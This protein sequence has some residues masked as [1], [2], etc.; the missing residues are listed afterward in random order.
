MKRPHDSPHLPFTLLSVSAHI[1]TLT[2]PPLT[3]VV[4]P[5]R[6]QKDGIHIPRKQASTTRQLFPEGKDFTVSEG[7]GDGLNCRITPLRVDTRTSRLEK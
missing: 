4:L 6:V 7:S 3:W 5:P 2:T 1:Y